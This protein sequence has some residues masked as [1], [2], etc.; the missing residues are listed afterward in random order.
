MS[1]ER[2]KQR[3]DDSHVSDKNQW[4]RRIFGSFKQLVED[5]ADDYFLQLG[6]LLA[7]DAQIQILL[8]LTYIAKESYMKDF[9]MTEEEITAMIQ[10]DKNFFYR[11]RA[12]GRVTEEPIIKERRNVKEDRN[13]VDCW[14][15]FT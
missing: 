6:Q 2:V 9:Q 10:K 5:Q 11:E 15:E 7:I 14:H 13:D 4:T 1:L 12:S 8:E 3:K